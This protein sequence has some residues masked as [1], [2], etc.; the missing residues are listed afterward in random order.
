MNKQLQLA[1][2]SSIE[3]KLNRTETKLPSNQ[4][5]NNKRIF[6]SPIRKCNP[7]VYVTLTP[8]NRYQHM[9][10][11]DMINGTNS[12]GIILP[13]YSKVHDYCCVIS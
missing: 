9:T 3:Q 8:L 1:S 5:S 2:T 6:H 12:V 4:L 10:E 13:T 7:V 11:N